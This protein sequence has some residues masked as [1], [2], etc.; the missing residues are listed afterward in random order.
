MKLHQTLSDVGVDLI[1]LAGFM[2]ILSGEFVRKWRGALL[3][4]HPS[5]L[6]SF[7]GMHAQKQAIEAGVRLSGCSV[8]F[9]VVRIVFS[10]QMLSLEFCWNFVCDSQ[11]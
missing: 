3:N 8:H 11:A 2:R 10:F 9:V 7:P 6:P 4:I 1:C 5:L